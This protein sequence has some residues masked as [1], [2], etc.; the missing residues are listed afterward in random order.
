VHD[1]ARREHEPSLRRPHGLARYVE[2]H[3]AL[4]DVE[5]V[6][7]LAMEVRGDTTVVGASP[8]L[9]HEQL[10]PLELRAEAGL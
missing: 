3:L 8:D 9:E 7:V 5:G 1:A 10:W 2:V 4:E 6:G